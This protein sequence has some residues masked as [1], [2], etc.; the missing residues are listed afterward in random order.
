MLEGVFYLVTWPDKGRLPWS[1]TCSAAQ[2][3]C[4]R[5]SIMAW[6]FAIFFFA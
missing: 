5:P 2:M 4:H 1:G 3:I 6:Q